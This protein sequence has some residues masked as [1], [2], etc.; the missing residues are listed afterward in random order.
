MRIHRH[1]QQKPKLNVPEFKVNEEILSET[2]RV[3]DEN[4]TMLGVMPTPKALEMAQ[5]KE[6]D[7]VEVSPKAVPPVVKFL[8]YGQFR[9]QKEKEAKKQKAQSKEI[10]VKGV[11]LSLRIADGDFNVRLAAAKKFMEEGNKI[12]MEM[13]LRGREKGHGDLAGEII[14]KFIA[15]LRQTFPLRIEQPVKRMGGRVTAIVARE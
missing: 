14:E 7:L 10:E 15:A 1:R 11:R 6:L 4:D 2:V 9:Y 8:N 5:G 13:I 3:I 12:R